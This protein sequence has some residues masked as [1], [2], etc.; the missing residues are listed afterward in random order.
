MG[1]GMQR[2][3]LALLKGN[4]AD[5]FYHYPALFPMFFMFLFLILHLVF[6]FKNGARW[7]MYLFIF[8]IAIVV[9]SYVIKLAL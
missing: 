6:K 2:S 4:F 1:C 7:L 9:I 5:S 8:N 3:F